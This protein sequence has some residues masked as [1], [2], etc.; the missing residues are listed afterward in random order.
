[1][2]FKIVKVKRKLNLSVSL[3]DL[4]KYGNSLNNL[5]IAFKDDF[6][7]IGFDADNIKL[8]AT[9]FNRIV[10]DVRADY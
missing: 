4:A 2:S 10:I 3:D 8:L 6:G 5:I 7:K 1:M 9:E